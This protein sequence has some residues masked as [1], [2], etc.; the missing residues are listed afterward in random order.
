M[1]KFLDDFLITMPTT[2][3]KKLIELLELQQK[4]GK[5]KTNYEM[6]AELEKLL[7][8][9]DGKN[10]GPT[11]QARMQSKQTN[12]KSYNENMEEIAFDLATLFEASSTIDRFIDDNKQ[13]SKSLLATIRKNVY[14]LQTKVNRYKLIMKNTDGFVDG[15]HEQF[16]AP[17]YIETNETVLQSLRKDRFDKYLDST[18]LAENVGDALQLAGVETIDQLRTNYGR[19]LA[20]INVLNRTGYPSENPNHTIDQAIDGS[21]NTYWAESILVD[22]PIKQNI[23][24]LWK[25]D[26]QEVPKDG[27][28]CELEITLNGV[29]TVSDIHFEP[30]CAYPLEIVSIYGYETEDMNGKMYELIS[31][32]HINPMQRNKKSVNLMTFQ[33]PSVDVSKIKILLRQ[34]NYVSEN[35]IVN[36]DEAQN[37]QLWRKLSSSEQLIPDYKNPNETIAEFDK[38]NEI[39]GWSVYLEKL[40]E[41]ALSVNESGV[42]ESAKR[43]MEAIRMGDYKNPMLLKL[44]ALS[45]DKDNT[46]NND[47]E[48][49]KSWKAVNKISYLYGAY[50]ISIFGRKYKNHSIMVT[51]PLPLSSNANKIGLSTVEKHHHLEID[52]AVADPIT[53]ELGSINTAQITD[54]EYYITYKKNPNASDWIPILPN[55]KKYV[56]GELLSGDMIQGDYPEFKGHSLIQYS[57]RFPIVS[58]KTVVL[59]RNG[60]PM[61]PQTYIISNDGKKIGIFSKYYSASSIYTVDYKPTDEAYVVVLDYENNITPTQYIDVNG[62]TGES[63]ESA[64]FNNAIELK[65]SPYLFRN[66]LFKYNEKENRYAQNENKT[67]EFPII[68]RVNGEEFKNIT[69][70]ATNTYDTERLTENEG[71]TFAQIGK[72]IVFGKPIDGAK[73]ENITVDYYYVTTDIRL[74]AIL[75]RNSMEDASVTPALYSYSI[76]CQSYDQEV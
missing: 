48:L 27:A 68:V 19:K 34:E 38:K 21:L 55:D 11:F 58:N 29:T 52:N 42:L 35:F 18:F 59:R 4:E 72:T 75:R 26:Y 12:S 60:V 63:F 17:E 43:A 45:K 7:T 14:A 36:K 15:I 8:E 3:R 6:Q 57:F 70:H 62:D 74:K 69:N 66:S 30:F 1:T 23:N 56:Y 24:D 33:F 41:W 44:Q 73:I 49:K 10:N 67:P 28:L 64:D 50:N 13:L 22:Q 54:I 16:K 71:K 47:E 46:I 37:M 2:Q 20:H 53:K 39:T 25:N 76:K 65:H 31:L 40:K 51:E 5:I 9:L 32:N 61:D